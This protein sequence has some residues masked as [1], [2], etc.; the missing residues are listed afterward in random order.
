MAL[1]PNKS[2]DFVDGY[3]NGSSKKQVKDYPMFLTQVNLKQF[4]H[5][6]GL[7]FDIKHPITVISGT[8]RMGKT[9]ILMTIACSHYNFDRQDVCNGLWH[10][11]T[12]SDLVRFTIHD[13]QK[14]DWEYELKYR[15]GN[16]IHTAK[17]YRRHR[18]KKWGGAGTKKQQIGHPTPGHNQGGRHVCLIDLNR[19]TPGRHLSVSAYHKSRSGKVSPIENEND[20]NCYL[21]YIL[22]TEYQAQKIHQVADNSVFKFNV[23]NYAYSSFN[24]AS[25]EDVL[26]NL[27][28]QVL[29]LPDNSLILIDELEVGLHPK[30][31]RRLMDVLYMISH[32]QHKQFIIVS[33]S[34]AVI[35]SVVPEARIFIDQ[36]NGHH[37]VRAGLSTYEILTRMDSKSFATVSVYVEDDVSAMIVKKAMD[38]INTENAGFVRLVNVIEVGSADKTYNY[39]KTR[40]LLRQYEPL[41]PKPIC[42]LDGDMNGKCDSQ[43]RLLY[44]P[45]NDLFFHL[46]NLAPERMLVQ[47]YLQA[48]P[49]SAMSYHL[50]NSNAHCL[51]TKMVEEGSA[52]SK[53]DAFEKCY[54][55]MIAEQ[56]GREHMDKLKSFLM[57][58]V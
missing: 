42:V 20:V 50:A 34:Y 46:S 19:I 15:Q 43:G 10:R 28:S 25:G 36:S 30:V 27:L 14:V 33:H 40:Q 47:H 4:R 45:E 24:T 37:M 18:T 29:H 1:N 54:S 7:S 17:G 2:R 8:N 31:Q 6:N 58:S 38:E 5:I 21:S 32:K 22:E 52:S 56:A 55:A 44:A 16:N 49:N 39:F 9:S 11:A 41:T 13:V 57:R 51:F 23:P 26:I 48:N 53:N 35:D 3:M 12:W